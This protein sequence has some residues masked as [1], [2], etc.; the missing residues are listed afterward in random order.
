MKKYAV[1]VVVLVLVRL[2]QIGIAPVPAPESLDKTEWS[3]QLA[4]RMGNAS[5]TG[6][7]VVF[8]NSWQQAEG[9]KATFNPLATTQEMPGATC[10]NPVPCVKNYLT[11]NDGLDAILLTLKGNYPGYADIVAGIQ[12][13]DPET[14]WKGLKASPWGTQADLVATIYNEAMTVT[15]VANSDSDF[16]YNVNC[17]LKA[18]NN[19]L[20][21]F[22]IAPSSSWSFNAAMGDPRDGKICYTDIGGTPGAGW[23]NLAAEY[24][25]E[26]RR[27][28]LDVAFVDHGLGDIGGGPENSVTIWNVDGQ[29]GFEGERKDLIIT[30]TTTHPVAFRVTKVDNGIA[31]IVVQGG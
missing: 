13:N 20:M 14:A 2:Y 1:G 17:A 6:E 30:N 21:A 19:A 24:A 8:I 22:S 27:A 3:Y 31:T 25:Q 4:T 10:F 29:P 18:N 9:S 23:C 7:I 12:S 26:A 11:V 28:G 5:P 15:V 16:A